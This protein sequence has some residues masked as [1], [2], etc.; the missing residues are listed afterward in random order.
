MIFYNEVLK[1]K[2]GMVVKCET[3][4]REH[5]AAYQH[6]IKS[7][8]ALAG[9]KVGRKNRLSVMFRPWRGGR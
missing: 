1:K 8:A 9:Q 2:R 4:L 6:G 7:Y 3:S 5:W